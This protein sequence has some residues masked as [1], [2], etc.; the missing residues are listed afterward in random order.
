VAGQL[1]GLASIRGALVEAGIVDDV[2]S[3]L[4][5]HRVWD[6]LLAEA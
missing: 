5:G 4:E 3:L 1:S 2:I 6:R